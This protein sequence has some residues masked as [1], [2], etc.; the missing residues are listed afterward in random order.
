M[1]LVYKILLSFIVPLVITLGLWGWLSYS[2]MTRKIHADTDLIL[3]DYTENII[4]RKLSGHEMPER[5]NGVYNTYYIHQVSAEYAAENPQAV[6]DEAESYLKSQ[7]EFASSRIRKQVFMDNNGQY[8]EIIVSMPTFEQEILI[9]HVL[10]WTIL[11]FAV[12]FIA[13]L[14]IGIRVISRNMRPLFAL[15]NWMEHYIPG[16]KNGNIPSDTD[17]LEF[18]RLA[19]VAQQAVDRFEHQYEERKMFIG[20]V[21]HELQTPLA[22]CSNRLEIMLDRPDLNEEMAGELIK[23]QRSL[24]HLIKLNKT[25]LLLSRIE[26]KQYPD[27]K[28]IDIGALLSE[29][30]N[31]NNEIWSFKNIVANIEKKGEFTASINEQMASVLVGNLVK[32]A[33][34]HSTEGSSIEIEIDSTGFCISNPGEYPLDDTKIFHRFYQ[35]NGRREGSTGLGLALAYSVCN[36]NDLTI[37]YS[38]TNNRHTFTVS[39]Q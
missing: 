31:E 35:P 21:S 25:L 7:E 34:V 30:I 10:W 23:L 29:T 18:K 19:T 22:V 33:Y 20:N 11:L 3:K 39:K 9:E 5:F 28:I 12:L 14:I 36:N 13:L 6:Y 27:K 8:Y 2:T 15:L 37:S 1:K 17:I 38:F 26:N 32:N 16:S 4:L 24:R